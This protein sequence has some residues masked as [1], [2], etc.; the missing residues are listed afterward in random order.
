MRLEVS[1]ADGHIARAGEPMRAAVYYTNKDIRLEERSVPRIG[2]GEVL[3]K[4][5]ACGLCGGEAMEWYLA[6]RAPKILGHEPAG[7][8]VEVGEGVSG[9]AVGDRVF[10]HHHVPCNYC[11]ECQRGAPTYCATYSKTN[12]DPGGFADYFRVPADN[13]PAMLKLPEGVSFEEA[14]VIEPM[15]DCLYGLETLSVASGDTIA[16]QG[17]GFMGLCFVQL[18]RLYP[19]ARIVALDFSDWRLERALEM[20][21]TH[22]INPR[23][24]DA[25]GKLRD[26]NAG[27][28][29][30]A[31]VSTAPSAKAWESAL[32]L[33]GKGGT[34]HVNAP[35]HPNERATVDPN[36]LYFSGIT[37]NNAYSSTKA[38]TTAVLELI[39]GGRVDAGALI[40][41]R[42]G[43]DGAAEGIDLIV[44]AGESIKSVIIPSLTRTD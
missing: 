24:E 35:P 39:A 11:R 25:V 3:V 42:F 34:L 43:F 41:H 30:D 27:R 18:A 31:V 23:R 4:T 29:A 20:G 5:E 33:V 38:E 19:Y 8:I 6:P 17:V 44:K 14:C 36:H 21:A 26:I 16:I 15:S 2:P 40:T 10:V 9:Y 13:V 12:I 37:I 7:V 1:P 22:T 28:L 32:S